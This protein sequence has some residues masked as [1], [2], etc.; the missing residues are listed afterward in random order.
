V[1]A[2][3][4]AR[5]FLRGISVR[6][7]RDRITEAILLGIPRSEH[8]DQAEMLDMQ[9]VTGSSP[10][11]PTNHEFVLRT[12]LCGPHSAGLGHHSAF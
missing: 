10:V 1:I 2:L 9:E 3:K 5:E 6:H 4:E 11:S 8:S 12:A 7:D